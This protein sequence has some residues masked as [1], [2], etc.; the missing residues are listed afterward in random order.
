[1]FHSRA[2]SIRTKSALLRATISI[3]KKIIV[4]CFL[5]YPPK[6]QRVFHRIFMMWNRTIV[7]HL[8]FWWKKLFTASMSAKRMPKYRVVYLGGA[9]RSLILTAWALILSPA[10]T[11]KRAET[12]TGTHSVSFRCSTAS[13]GRNSVSLRCSTASVLTDFAIVVDESILSST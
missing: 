3:M 8:L 1:M 5:Y 4:Y 6:I 7:F 13:E 11:D 2:T 9:S 10:F 12:K